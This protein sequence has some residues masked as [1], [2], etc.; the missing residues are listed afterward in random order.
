[1]ERI[2]ATLSRYSP[3]LVF[4]PTSLSSSSISTTTSPPLSP[5][6]P[7]LHLRHLSSSC[8]LAVGIFS[9][10][11]PLA[12]SFIGSSSLCSSPPYI[13]CLTLIP[14]Q[15]RL[16]AYY[17]LAGSE[18]RT[19]QEEETY[20]PA[21]SMQQFGRK[22]LEPR[23]SELV[24]GKLLCDCEA[25]PTDLSLSFLDSLFLRACQAARELEASPPLPHPPSRPSSSRPSSSRPSSSSS[26]ETKLR[27]EGFLAALAISAMHLV[28]E[29]KSLAGRKMMK[30]AGRRGEE[31][32]AAARERR[33]E[34]GREGGE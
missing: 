7:H 16:H 27:L 12:P 26:T 1:M 34:G 11:S 33:R 23:N 19:R 14:W 30:R 2:E 28:Q 24:T 31:K 21:M 15:A 17:S 10:S 8:P 5:P 29:S 22:G 6:P 25:I 4:S 20:R 13:L 18:M 9:S 32:D 3:H